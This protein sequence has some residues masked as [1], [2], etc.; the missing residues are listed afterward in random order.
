LVPLTGNYPE[1]GGTMVLRNF[2]TLLQ[3]YTASQ[4]MRTTI[5]LSVV[6]YGCRIWPL[7]RRKEHGLRRLA[8]LPSKASYQMAKNSQF[9]SYVWV[10]KRR[11][12][13]FRKSHGKRRTRTH[14]E[15]GKEW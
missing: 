13:I 2:G 11:R 7:T 15:S 5:S 10:R 4:P 1:D 12:D 6:L 8:D 14:F 9:Q 3:H